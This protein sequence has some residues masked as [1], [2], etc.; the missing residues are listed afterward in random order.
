[1]DAGNSTYR[2]GTVCAW[3]GL[4]LFPVSLV[5]AIPVWYD[6]AFGI[7]AADPGFALFFAFAGLGL[8]HTGIPLMGF[9]AE[10]MET[11]ARTTDAGLPGNAQAG[12][13]LYRQSW[14]FLG[15]GALVLAAA[16]PFVIVGALEWNRNGSPTDYTGLGLGLAGLGLMSVGAIEQYVSGYR[17]YESRRQSLA[18][19]RP[20]IGVSLQPLIHLS[21]EGRSGLG[22]RMSC[23]F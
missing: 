2:A 9:G 4:A 10:R 3:T 1:M 20:Q 11:A 6:G 7:T 13:A 21:R 15:G 8:I 16:V 5:A 22:L 12:W 18:A 17:F 19:T 14:K 23:R